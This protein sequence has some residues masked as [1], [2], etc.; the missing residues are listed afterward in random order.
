MQR[1]PLYEC[2]RMYFEYALDREWICY[3]YKV[4][5]HLFQITWEFSLEFVIYNDKENQARNRGLRDF[6]LHI[7][8]FFRPRMV[9]HSV[10]IGSRNRP[11][12]SLAGH[13]G[14]KFK[15]VRVQKPQQ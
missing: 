10:P 12:L 4:P 8:L 13:M 5:N 7:F 9:K 3:Y 1:V 14:H 15:G 11:R 2:E 6:I